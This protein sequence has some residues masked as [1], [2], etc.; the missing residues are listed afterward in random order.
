MFRFSFVAALAL[1][2][3]LLQ[4]AQAADTDRARLA[5][6]RLDKATL[7]KVE[8]AIDSMADVVKKQPSLVHGKE[9]DVETIAGMAAFYDSRPPL[10]KAIEGA[11][12]TTDAFSAFVMAWVQSAF[13]QAM[14]QTVPA[15]K[16]AKATADTG[17]PPANLAF[18]E[19]NKDHLKKI[20]DKLAAMPRGQ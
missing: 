5:A 13:A 17:V 3:S 15:D 4:P 12:L 18:V 1:A 14:I 16:R 2:A 19:T 20:S 7:V 11:G 10:K 6:Y 8:A 9:G